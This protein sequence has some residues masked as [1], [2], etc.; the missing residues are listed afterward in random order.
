M[1]NFFN[2]WLPIFFGCHCKRERS[3][4]YKNKQFPICARCTGELLGMVS[5]IFLLLILGVPSLKICIVLMIPMVFDGFLQMLT[6][7][8]SN[9]IKRVITGYFFGIGF[10]ALIFKYILSGVRIGQY[11]G[12]KY[13]K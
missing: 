8:E 5:G 7:Y 6:K 13:F 4:V 11:I 2:K 3:F 1:V 10:M 9:N 12:E